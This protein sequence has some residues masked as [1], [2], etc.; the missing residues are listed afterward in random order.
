[1]K[2]MLKN[3]F[4]VTEKQF[5]QQVIDLAKLFQ[6]E[7]YFTWTSIHSPRGMPDLILCKPPR[8]VFA[9]LKTLKGQPTEYQINWLNLLSDC[10]GNE[11]FLWRPDDWDAIQA[12]LTKPEQYQ[13]T[14]RWTR[15]NHRGI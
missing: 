10:P 11:C 15:E 7:C 4:V 3:P 14:E 5:R 13:G 12:V 6:W 2:T 8:V 1:M 9:E